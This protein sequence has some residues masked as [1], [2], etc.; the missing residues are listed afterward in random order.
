MYV[1]GVLEAHLLQGR[2]GKSV[3]TVL[4]DAYLHPASFCQATLAHVAFRNLIVGSRRHLPCAC[5]LTGHGLYLHLGTQQLEEL[6]LAA[7]YGNEIHIEHSLTAAHADEGIDLEFFSHL[8]GPLSHLLRLLTAHLLPLRKQQ[9]YLV[10]VLAVVT[11]QGYHLRVARYDA[12]E[13]QT[14]PIYIEKLML[15]PHAL[16]GC[17]EQ[18]SKTQEKELFHDI[19]FR[20]SHCFT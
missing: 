10:F 1:V 2:P 12:V 9:T 11:L 16:H 17:K 7:Y 20:R 15:C 8:I 6:A 18:E 19:M 5:A 4:L 13:R 14:L 3:H